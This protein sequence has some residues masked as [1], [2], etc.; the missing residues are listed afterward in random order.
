MVG[1]A[2][3]T[4][5]KHHEVLGPELAYVAKVKNVLGIFEEN[6]CGIVVNENHNWP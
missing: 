5:L 3:N 6:V 4:H 1:T 2:E